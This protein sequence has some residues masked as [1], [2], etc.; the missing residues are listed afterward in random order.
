MA[1]VQ[2]MLDGE[3]VEDDVWPQP[4]IVDLQRRTLELALHA[5]R[6]DEHEAQRSKR[7]IERSLAKGGRRSL[8]R[9]LRA[10][11]RVA[12]QPLA[13]RLLLVRHDLVHHHVRARVGE[14]QSLQHR[15]INRNAH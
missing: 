6:S 7:R 12:V 11:E 10:H 13:L 15:D 8:E 4:K 1:A 3:K 5:G 2:R 9:C 14:D